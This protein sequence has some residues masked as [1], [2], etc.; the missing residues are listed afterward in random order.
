[1][2]SNVGFLGLHLAKAGSLGIARRH[3]CGGLRGK[4]ARVVANLG[5]PLGPGLG[6]TFAAAVRGEALI[7]FLLPRGFGGGLA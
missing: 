5:G 4:A 2:E 1:M 3:T 6:L 7:H